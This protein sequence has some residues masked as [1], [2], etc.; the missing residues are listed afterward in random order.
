MDTLSEQAHSHRAVEATRL[1]ATFVAELRFD[2]IPTT[3]IDEAKR[4]LV[5]YQGVALAGSRDA[6][7]E[8]LNAVY[9]TRGGA[10]EARLIDGS[11]K[12]DVLSAALLNGAA[13]HTLDFDDTHA[14][15]FY[16]GTVPV[17]PAVWA[18][19]EFL[20]VSGREFLTALVAGWDVGA[21][22]ARA[23]N[24]SIYAKGWQNTPTIGTFAAACS[25]AR[26]LKLDIDETR[27]A[28]GLAATQASGTRQMHG[29]M[30]KPFQV[31]KASMN[32]VLS[33]LLSREGV[34]TSP[35]ALEAPLGFAKLM[36]QEFDLEIAVAQLG[37]RFELLRNIYKPYACCLLHHPLVEAFMA[38][39]REHG[40]SAER[41]LSAECRVYASVLDSTN[42][43]DPTTGAQGKFS[44]Q[45]AAAVVLADNAAGLEQ[46]TTER[47]LDPALATLRGKMRFVAD[48]ALTSYDCVVTARCTDGA[49][50]E[51]RINKPRGC[52]DNPLSNADLEAKFRDAARE[53]I[54]V[55]RQDRTLAAI[56]SLDSAA[57][58]AAVVSQF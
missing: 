15:F 45:H 2:A 36:A 18:L 19:G 57:D 22:I 53:S 6:L 26:L 14:D 34:S 41:L 7:F 37:A 49:T 31:G 1:L 10:P 42:V 20:Q 32:G 55:Q 9:R 46:Y 30:S 13:A 48:P 24:P 39:H 11:R 28:I 4:A 5:D 27:H 21:R 35:I 40:V 12:T 52:I 47:V 58:I 56:H 51:V 50:V 33:A 3:V 8:K 16:H 25:A 17:A 29:T 44:I 54:N 43:D 38:L 23:L